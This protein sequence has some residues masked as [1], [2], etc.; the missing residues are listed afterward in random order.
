MHGVQDGGAVY[1]AGYSAGEQKCWVE[2][3]GM[4]AE[5]QGRCAEVHGSG[6]ER[7]CRAAVRNSGVC[8]VGVRVPARVAGA[9]RAARW[10]AG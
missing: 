4:R 7:G 1:G 3:Q 9:A 6:A 5:M 2:M 8:R 10:A